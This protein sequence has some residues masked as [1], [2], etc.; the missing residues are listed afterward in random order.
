MTIRQKRIPKAGRKRPARLGFLND[1]ADRPWTVTATEKGLVFR[2]YSSQ[3]KVTVSLQDVFLK[4]VVPRL[5][6]HLRIFVI[7]ETV[8]KN[9]GSLG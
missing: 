1:Q 6:S 5:P 2:R 8:P 3:V 7:T 4:I 9:E